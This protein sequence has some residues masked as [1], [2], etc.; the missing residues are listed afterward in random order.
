[1]TTGDHNA[2]AEH[3]ARRIAEIQTHVEMLPG[4]EVMRDIGSTHLVHAG[5]T[6][7]GTVLIPQPSASADD[8]LVCL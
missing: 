2:E 5:A 8:P 1:M 3:D 6:S 7:D 4:T